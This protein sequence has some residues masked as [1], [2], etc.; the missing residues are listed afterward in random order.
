M[1]RLRPDFEAYKHVSYLVSMRYSNGRI[2]IAAIVI[3]LFV[4]FFV[5]IS[6]KRGVNNEKYSEMLDGCYHIYVDVGSNIGIQVRKLFEPERYPE[7]KVLPIFDKVFGNIDH[8]RKENHANG[9]IICVVGFEPNP[10]HKRDLKELE[11]SYNTCGYKVKFFTE[12]AVSSFNGKSTLFSDENWKML[13]WSASLLSPD[14][15]IKV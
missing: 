13:E 14:L 1:K 15:S 9:K 2:C 5:N 4:G 6:I 7:G 10:R 3:I 12:T 11:A 8:R